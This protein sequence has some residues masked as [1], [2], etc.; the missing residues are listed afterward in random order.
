LGLS[1]I[2]IAYINDLSPDNKDF[3]GKWVKYFDIA[4]NGAMKE[5]SKM[6]KEGIIKAWGLG[7]NGSIRFLKPSS[8]PILISVCLPLSTLSSNKEKREKLLEI[9]KNHES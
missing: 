2:D 3:E 8:S 1:H 9:C 4:K 7:M 6:R 5:L